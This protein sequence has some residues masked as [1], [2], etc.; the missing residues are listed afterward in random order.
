MHLCAR[1]SDCWGVGFEFTICNAQLILSACIYRGTEGLL[2]PPFVAASSVH[3]GDAQSFAV[4]GRLKWFEASPH[5]CVFFLKKKEKTFVNKM[6]TSISVR[7]TVTDFRLQTKTCS[8]PC[9]SGTPDLFYLIVLVR[10]KKGIRCHFKKY[11]WR[12]GIKRDWERQQKTVRS[13]CP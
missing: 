6:Q 11:V 2:N 12:S 3:F 10:R 7:P 13:C 8:W 9:Y 4:F 5:R 1:R